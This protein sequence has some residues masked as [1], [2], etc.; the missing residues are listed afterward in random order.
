MLATHCS[1]DMYAN[2]PLIVPDRVR[3][4]RSSALAIPKSTS[5]TTPSKLITRFCGEISRCTMLSALPF[6]AF[7]WA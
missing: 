7:S 5:L 6:T 3:V 4:S 2:L 1:G